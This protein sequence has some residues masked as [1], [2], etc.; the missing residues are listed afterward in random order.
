MGGMVKVVS[1]YDN[2]WGFSN[3][4]VDL[5]FAC[6]SGCHREETH[7]RKKTVR[8]VEVAGKRVLVRV[9][10]NVPLDGRPGGRR[11]P[12]PGRAAHHR[13]PAGARAPR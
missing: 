2:E 7:V 8:D 10:F 5:V 4:M 11:H 13:V 3:R 1:W 9:D 6:S 12:H